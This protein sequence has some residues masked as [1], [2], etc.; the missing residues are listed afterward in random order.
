MASFKIDLS[1]CCEI[2][3]G[4]KKYKVIG[5]VSR[6][7]KTFFRL[8]NLDTLDLIGVKNPLIIDSELDVI[9]NK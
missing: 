8:Q 4:G 6:T 7:Q 2:E 1:N 3:V 9:C 5:E